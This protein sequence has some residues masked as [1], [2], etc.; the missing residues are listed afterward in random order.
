MMAVWPNGNSVGHRHINDITL[1]QA[2]LI[3]R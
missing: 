3:L 2:Q 1:R